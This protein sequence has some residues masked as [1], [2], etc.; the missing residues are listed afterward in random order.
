[1]NENDADPNITIEELFTPRISICNDRVHLFF[2]EIT[3]RSQLCFRATDQ[4]PISELILHL[5]NKFPNATIS[6]Q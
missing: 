2:G 4:H 1:M 5:S 6:Y 3:P